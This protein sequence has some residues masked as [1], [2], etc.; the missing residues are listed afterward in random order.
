MNSEEL[1]N[2]LMSEIE[3]RLSPINEDLANLETADEM[4][5]TVN[6]RRFSLEQRRVELENQL[7]NLRAI[8]S[9]ANALR[10]LETTRERDDDDL[11]KMREERSAREEENDRRFASLPLEMQR[12]VDN[13][14]QEELTRT[15]DRIASLRE[16]L[17]ELN[18]NRLTTLATEYAR[19][20]D[21][22]NRTLANEEH[23]LERLRNRLYTS[24]IRETERLRGL[25][26]ENSTE[27]EREYQEEIV[28]RLRDSLTDEQRDA[29][30]QATALPPNPVEG[31]WDEDTEDNE[32]ETEEEN[33]EET[34]DE[35][36]ETNQQTQN[37]STTQTDN[38]TQ[39]DD[40][41][42]TT[43]EQQSSVLDEDF[44]PLTISYADFVLRIAEERRQLLATT[45]E[46]TARLQAMDNLY[47][48]VTRIREQEKHDPTYLHDDNGEV[49][50][51]DNSYVPRP[52]NQAP[53]EDM[54]QYNSFL[55]NEYGRRIESIGYLRGRENT[56]REESILDEEFNPY[57][58]D[59]N[60]FSRRLTEERN[61]LIGNG[62]PDNAT[63]QRLS[64]LYSRVARVRA[65]ERYDPT[66]E[67]DENGNV[68]Y[69]ENTLIPM[70]RRQAYLEDIE[71][72]NEFLR[73]QYARRIAD[74]GY[75]PGM[76]YEE[77]RDTVPIITE[78]NVNME[79]PE[80]QPINVLDE[81]FNPFSI[82]HE[83]L[84]ERL[85]NTRAELVRENN[86]ENAD[87]IQ[88]IDEM[89]ARVTR[90]RSQE[91]YDPTYEH[92]ENGNI[93]YYENTFVP[94]PRRQAYLEDPEQYEAFVNGEYTRRIANAGYYPGM[95]YDDL[96]QMR[97]SQES[98]LDENF[99]PFSM[100]LEDFTNRYGMERQRVITE[101][102]EDNALVL[103]RMDDMYRRVRRARE[104]ERYDPTYE[105]D[106][107]GNVVY[108]PNSFIPR[109]RSQ[110]VL[111][112]PEQYHDFLINEY[113]RRLADVG[114]Y[115]EAGNRNN[116]GTA[117]TQTDDHSYELHYGAQPRPGLPAGRE[118]LGL[119][120]G[121]EP[122][123]LPAGHTPTNTDP[124]N[125]DPTNTDPTNTE[126]TNTDPTNTD[127]TNTDP[128]NADP[129]NTDPTNTDPT[130]T[131]PTNTD[132][133]NTD[134]TNADPTNTEP[135][136]TDPTNT[137]PTNT[138]PANTDP[139]NTDPTNTD[140]T[141]TDPTNTEPTKVRSLETILADIKQD[142][143]GNPLNFDDR[144]GKALKASRIRVRD[145]FRNELRNGSW[146][147]AIVGFVPGIIKGVVST[148]GKGIGKIYLRIKG[149]SDVGEQIRERIRNLS[150]RDIEVLFQQYRGNVALQRNESQVVNDA[151]MEVLREKGME[152]VEANRNR[153]LAMYKSIFN[154]YKTAQSYDD[155]IDH[156]TTDDEKEKLT[157]QKRDA[158][159]GTTGLIA[160]FSNLENRTN[161]ILS[162]GIHGQEEDL[163]AVN[164]KM[165]LQGIRFAKRPKNSKETLELDRK[166]GILA[167]IEL[168][169]IQTGN[170]EQAL[171][172]FVAKA[173]EY[174]RNTEEG[175]SVFGRR[176]TGRFNFTPLSTML[177]YRPDPFVRNLLTTIATVGATVSAVN[178]WH[179]HSNV[180]QTVDAHNDQIA[181]ANATN[182]GAIDQ[183]HTTGEQIA[184]YRET[185]GEGMKAQAQEDIIGRINTNERYGLDSSAEQYGGWAIGSDT[186]RQIDDAG[187]AAAEQ[188][189]QQAQSQLTDIA[190]QC[191]AGTMTHAQA[192][193]Q[194]SDLANSTQQS[195]N[196][197][198]SQSLPVLE[199]YIPGHPQ[200]ELDGLSQAMQYMVQ[201]PDVIQQMNQGMVDVTNL[202]D[203]LAG[204][205]AEQVQALGN[206]PS[207]L[208]TT[209]FGAASAAALAARVSSEMHHN[210]TAY[211][212]DRNRELR[213]M[214]IDFDEA[215][216]ERE[217]TDTN[218]RQRAA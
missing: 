117:D 52:R 19:R 133:T 168:R 128:T 74:A 7:A 198:L 123:G 138:E 161:A 8:S 186:Y 142:E 50:Y 28:K 173:L 76:T 217:N 195:F 210:Q 25:S 175:R 12:E 42:T 13:F 56:Q 208:A 79:E 148:I 85:R 4:D 185:F 69:F 95:T 124:T 43:Q 11:V 196:D 189:Q 72:Y 53:L 29:L 120:A 64:E 150:D 55:V 178:A 176:S 45:P 58:I 90:V 204:L 145:S 70:P 97:E 35:N 83:E 87:A 18:N 15:E 91:R 114:Y 2:R 17:E 209:L 135:T 39:G 100:S 105:H 41:Q 81:N 125:T 206:L 151:I 46:D 167:D 199:Q 10:Q 113:G 49:V 57:S 153:M 94:M 30:G 139:A 80:A 137:E 38:N 102:R 27:D 188:M 149:Q 160:E 129:T 200:F 174:A 1:I 213:D 207:D 84:N 136:N 215:Q 122:L 147:Y 192:L 33:V 34:Q 126:P 93:V 131:E 132:P 51:Y 73:G 48:Q 155:A 193:Q 20:Q 112:E 96:L 169:A 152:R 107:N 89:Y 60:E 163:N 190:N 54:E 78:D 108:Y 6:N 134:P 116:L 165:N 203:S 37:I 101:N 115:N 22:I 99:N 92:D 109:P 130:N 183:A 31:T 14:A 201:N 3:T 65:Q 110:G 111:E 166:L 146:L 104:Q 67:H 71:Q 171:T 159:A 121:R 44:N 179:T 191:A 66:Y 24:T 59:F 202:G 5:D 144:T 187:H 23:N 172:A 162:D 156:A 218:S 157:K 75:Y 88:R 86:P 26:D 182:Q 170:D 32:N 61:R 140:P 21:E 63:L 62:N 77:L 181:N 36:E 68:V 16:D 9:N 98:I 143:N 47:M 177:D 141:N 212:D 103:Q 106:E 82:S 158:L 214:V 118:P 205:T 216:R 184:G 119:P 211:A 194:L 180:Q 164:S 154:R 127:P 40:T 197:L